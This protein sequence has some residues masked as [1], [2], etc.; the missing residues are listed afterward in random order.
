MSNRMAE[1]AVSAIRKAEPR[2]SVQVTFPDGGVLEGPVGTP[3][4]E[5]IKAHGDAHAGSLPERVPVV[6][7]IVYGWL[8]ELT[9][10]VTRDV[11]VVPVT[12]DTSDGSRVYRRSLWF[13][14]TVTSADIFPT[15]QVLIALH[16]RDAATS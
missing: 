7:V 15:T 16:L 8:R 1:V 6:A 9:M 12:T 11:S 5:F 2:T 10:P 3:L 4:E 13:L 14:L